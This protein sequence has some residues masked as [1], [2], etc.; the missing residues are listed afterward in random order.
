MVAQSSTFLER[1]SADVF[2]AECF[3]QA[4][5][6]TLAALTIPTSRRLSRHILKWLW[7][8]RAPR[9]AWSNSARRG[10]I[11]TWAWILITLRRH[12]R[13][14]LAAD[15]PLKCVW[16]VLAILWLRSSRRASRPLAALCTSTAA[17][18]RAFA[19]SAIFS[20]LRL[21]TEA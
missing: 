12:T 17:S 18:L 4:A 9:L 3:L 5:A 14:F 20:A 6:I 13:S 15:R 2:S 16:T 1:S 10:H 19:S 8:A 21:R 11:L 7:I